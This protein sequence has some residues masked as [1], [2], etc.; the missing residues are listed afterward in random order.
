MDFMSIFCAACLQA[1]TKP[2]DAGEKSGQ[3][4]EQS[5]AEATAAEHMPQGTR[6]ATLACPSLAPGLLPRD[7]DLESSAPVP[8]ARIPGMRH[9]WPPEDAVKKD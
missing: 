1:T 4:P 5:S 9:S 8:A 2:E 6:D 7:L 3:E